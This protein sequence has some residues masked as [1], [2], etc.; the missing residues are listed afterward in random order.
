MTA[1]NDRRDGR[2]KEKRRTGMVFPYDVLGFKYVPASYQ[3][4]NDPIVRRPTLYWTG[5]TREAPR[6]LKK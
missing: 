5:G 1:L 4:C 3:N 6:T 2:E